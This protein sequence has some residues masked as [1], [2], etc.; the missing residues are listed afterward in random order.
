[1][2]IRDF[3][4][5]GVILIVVYWIYYYFFVDKTSGQLLN[6]HN[7]QIKKTINA[8]KLPGSSGSS[9]FGYSIWIYVNDWDYQYGNKKVI[10]ERR[11]GDNHVGPSIYLGRNTNDLHIEM[12]TSSTTGVSESPTETCILHNVPIQ[13]W[14]HIVVT[15]NNKT[16]DAYLD[17]KLVKTCVLNGVPRMSKIRNEPIHITPEGGFSGFVSNLKYHS[18]SLNPREVMELYKEGYSGDLL[19]AMFNR[20]KLKFSI[21]KDNNEITSLQL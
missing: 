8:E 5:W 11:S 7:G 15:T 19:G 21:F 2:D 3:I 20:F 6:L 10:L 16:I 18:R 9:D 13:K 17:G 12:T 14:C 4:L 1:M